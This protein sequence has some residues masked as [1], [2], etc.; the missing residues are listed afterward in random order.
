MIWVFVAVFILGTSLWSLYILIKQKRVWEAFSKKHEMEFIPAAILKSPMLRGAFNGVKVMVYSDQQI[1]G[2][3]RQKKIRTVFE[4]TLTAPMPTEGAIASPVFR[5]FI[6]GLSLPEK[7]AP[8]SPEWNK[9]YIVNVNKAEAIA[10]YFSKERV[11]ALSSILGLKSSP[12]MILFSDAVTVMR[13]ESSDPF[14]DAGKLER[15]LTKMTEA[16]KIISL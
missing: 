2:N 9:D 12:V 4:F 6:N 13:V 8:D 11:A 5:N 10:P 14:D 1:G 3:E 15:F 16:V 7:F